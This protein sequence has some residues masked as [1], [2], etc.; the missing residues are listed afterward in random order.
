MLFGMMSDTEQSSPGAGSEDRVAAAPPAHRA[1]PTTGGPVN[2]AP[3]Q[4]PMVFGVIG[5]ILAVLHLIGGA[6][7]LLITVIAPRLS[8]ADPNAIGGQTTGANALELIPPAVLIPQHVAGVVLAGVLLAA[9]VWL[10]QRRRRGVRWLRTY[11][12]ASIAVTLASTAINL[13]FLTDNLSLGGIEIWGMVVGLV[14]ALIFP[15]IALWWT[16]KSRI[17]SDVETWQP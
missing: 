5:I 14:W 1:P 13:P 3:S 17:K 9:S 2:A 16:G 8:D 4:W 11:S 6:A 7:A 10:L 12:I 15:V